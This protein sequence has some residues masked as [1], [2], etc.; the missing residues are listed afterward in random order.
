VKD[1]IF[2]WWL[3]HETKIEFSESELQGHGKIVNLQ[4]VTPKEKE[5][6]G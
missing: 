4:D 1:S 2:V 6:G 3:G 5:N